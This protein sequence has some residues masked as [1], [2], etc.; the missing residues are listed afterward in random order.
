MNEELAEQ[1][2]ALYTMTQEQ[3]AEILQVTREAVT[4]AETRGMKKIKALLKARGYTMKD[5]FGDI[6]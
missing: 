3:V 5:F 1:D 6:K 4:Q 2:P